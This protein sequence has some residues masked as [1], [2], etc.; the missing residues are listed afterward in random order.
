MLVFFDLRRIVHGMKQEAG[1][2][3]SLE[4]KITSGFCP[5]ALAF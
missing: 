3:K 5:Q 2:K 4:I 1:D